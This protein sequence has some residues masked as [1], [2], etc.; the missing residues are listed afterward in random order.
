[1]RVNSITKFFSHFF[2]LI[3]LLLSHLS[4]INAQVLRI[5][6]GIVQNNNSEPL[7]GVSVVIRNTKTNFTSGTSTDSSGVF[8]FSNL[9]SAGPY[10]FAF[11][12]IGYENQKLAGYSIK[13]DAALSLKVILKSSMATLDQVVVVGYGTQKKVSLTG[14]VS[15]IKGEE[16]ERRPVSNVAQALQGQLPGVTILDNG[17]AP[18]K[19][20][21]KIRIRGV[22]TLSGDNNPL[23]IVDGIEQRLGDINA[24]DIETVSVLK[25][26]SSTAIYGSR[27]A[28]GVM[29]ITTKRAKTGKVSVAYNSFYAV[30]KS[31]NF[32]KH[33]GLE[34]YMRL[35]NVA[36]QN[37]GAAAIYT[38]QQI[39]DYIQGNATDPFKYPLPYSM[40]DAVLRP[41]PQIN[42]SLSVSGGT[43]NFKTRLSLR[44]QDQKGIIPNSKSN[45]NEIRINTD[46]NVSPKI[47]IGADINY[48]NNN[49]LAPVEEAEVFQRLKHGS[50]WT[51]PKYP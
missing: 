39:Q 1:M 25:D 11:S 14:A 40:V 49:S 21:V 18:G 6:K 15:Q 44:Y 38:E 4:Y 10:S 3:F 48:R 19:A 12:I 9:S 34:D 17:G 50:L 43:E 24:S 26:A 47:K 30:Q 33:M 45:L 16:L 31:V 51:V 8:T 23:V 46:F 28:N 32:P 2:V 37:I 41:A 36:Y 20:D 22:T 7:A 29:L 5:V 42:H 35:Q 27:A 13:D